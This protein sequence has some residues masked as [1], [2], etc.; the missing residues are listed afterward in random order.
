MTAR[1]TSATS[2]RSTRGHSKAPTARPSLRRGAAGSAD[3]AGTGLRAADRGTAESAGGA[4]GEG[5]EEAALAA[6]GAAA[7]G[8]SMKEQTAGKIRAQWRH[9]DEQW[10]RGQLARMKSWEILALLTDESGG[11]ATPPL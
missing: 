5:V 8:G 2:G 4:G 1:A 6:V 10:G 7:G 3:R 9:Q 11:L